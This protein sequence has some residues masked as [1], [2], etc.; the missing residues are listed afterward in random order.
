MGTGED[1]ERVEWALFKVTR[2]SGLITDVR[3]RGP[4]M[5]LRLNQ[6]VAI[7][8]SLDARLGFGSVS[9]EGPVWQAKRSGWAAQMNRCK[10][11]L[12]SYN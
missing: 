7:W 8:A 10:A 5:A 9:L 1:G 6:G 2:R 11:R 12:Q 4:D 3:E